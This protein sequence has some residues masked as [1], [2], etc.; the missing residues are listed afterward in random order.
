VRQLHHHAHWAEDDFVGCLLLV[1]GQRAVK[2]ISSCFQ[3]AH[4]LEPRRQHCLAPSEFV[5]KRGGLIH[6]RHRMRHRLHRARVVPH[7][8]RKGVS[9]RELH[10]GD[11]QFGLKKGETAFDVFG[12]HGRATLRLRQHPHEG[13][14]ALERLEGPKPIA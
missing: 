2:G 1:R 13:G 3:L 7:S 5:G 6:H 8:L 9:E 12:H 4:G 14:I 10:A 11:L